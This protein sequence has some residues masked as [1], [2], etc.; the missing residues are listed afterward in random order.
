ME[1]MMTGGWANAHELLQF[2]L[3]QLEQEGF[4]VPPAARERLDALTPETIA[5]AD[6]DVIE[7]ML[8]ALPVRANFTYDEPNELD[9]IRALRPER[10]QRAFALDLDQDALLDRFH[11]AWLGRSVGCALGK[12][13]EGLEGNPGLSGETRRLAA[14]GLLLQSRRR[15]RHYAA[16]PQFMPR[17]D[18][19]YGV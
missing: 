8:T 1:M 10:K 17:G 18:R 15:R 13:V 4:E 14:D 9:A 2:E 19:I 3:T 11:G 7:S 6:V 16:L 5:Q 12:P